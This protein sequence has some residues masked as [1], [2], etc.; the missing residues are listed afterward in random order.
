V[1]GKGDYRIRAVHI[2]DLAALALAAGAS[3]TDTVTD[4][5]GPERLTF[6]ELVRTIRSAVGSRSRIVRVPGVLVPPLATLLGL[7][8]RDVLLTGEE[9]RA[10]AAGLADTEG[11]ATGTI[12]V[13]E[14]I[15]ANADSLG[16]AYANEIDRHFRGKRS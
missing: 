2:D 8:L 5:V 3:R 7:V 9:Y 14:W 10:M 13:S 4:A 15:R 11:P 12:A 16:R 1:G 6:L